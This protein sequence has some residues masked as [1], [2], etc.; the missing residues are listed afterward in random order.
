[1][2]HKII[3]IL[4]G[5]CCLLS[6]SAAYAQTNGCHGEITKV[7]SSQSNAATYTAIDDWEEVNLPDSWASRWNNYD[8]YVW[9]RVDWIKHCKDGHTE[10]NLALLVES[11][12]MAGQIFINDHLIWSDKNLAEPLSRSWNQPRYFVLSPKDIQ[13]E[14]NHV[15][16]QV[17]GNIINSA[18]LGKVHIDDTP[19]IISSY[20]QMVWNQRTIFL[21]NIILSASLGLF[22]AC[23]WLMRKK[24]VA[25][26]WYAMTS[27]F[28]VLFISN[29]LLTETA[30]FAN[31][32][33]LLQFNISAFLAYCVSICVFT[34]RF[35]NIRLR[36]LEKMLKL[37]GLLCLMGIWMF[38]NVSSLAWVFY[39]CVLILVVNSAYIV[40]K[41]LFSQNKESFLLGMTFVV[42]IIMGM[43][44]ILNFLNIIQL[45]F[46]LLPYTSLLFTVF[47]SVILAMRLT[48]SLSNIEAFN[49]TL[50]AEVKKAEL[51]LSEQLKQ[52]HMLE[53][54]HLQ[55][56]ERVKLAH[57]LHD[58]L[59][60]SIV[61]SIITLEN[62][63]QPT[64]Q[65]KMLSILKLLRNDLR[66]IIDNFSDENAQLPD[67]PQLWLAPIRNRFIQIFD[68][69]DISFKWEVP[70]EWHCQPNTMMCL[71]FYRIAEES[72]TNIIKHSQATAV[73][74]NLHTSAEKMV[75]S[76][77]DNG[78][79]FDVDATQASGVS[80]GMVSMK[81]RIE[82][83]QGN[84]HIESEPGK[85][86]V[87]ATVYLQ[88][89]K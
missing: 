32:V 76:I 18:G 48:Q 44:S 26:G 28:W 39:T 51:S 27:L 12:N 20:D 25:L 53:M 55:L 40:K 7:W 50:V 56:N 71:T 37:Y 31:S 78:V 69:W 81:T 60:G 54:K 19:T 82:K 29:V 21:I 68:D 43:A 16:F 52:Q 58:S 42:C 1:M 72:L 2:K 49:E 86:V 77:Q 30:P 63:T 22:C 61:R 36:K 3:Q 14:I 67:S 8:G 66:Q 24:E 79:G 9:Y 65:H 34:W 75:L 88:Q 80:V 59:G 10:P 64:N 70:D 62:T 46:L 73:V 84:L 89:I 74:F 35:V 33:I 13:Q 57:D 6:L 85:T 4:I 87:R 15:Y 38:A 47:L 11:I 83:L 5:L 17:N 45:P 41:T 23:I